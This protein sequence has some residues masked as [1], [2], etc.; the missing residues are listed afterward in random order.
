MQ[1]E[2]E[3]LVFA[4]EQAKHKLVDLEIK[5]GIKQIPVPTQSISYVEIKKEIIKKEEPRILTET[6][7]AGKPKKEKKHKEQKSVTEDPPIDIG[8]L[9]LR[10][11]LIMD[12]QRH[13]DADSLYVL[14][15]NCKEEKPRTVCSGLVKHIPIEE[16][17]NRSVVLLCNLKPVK[18]H[19]LI[20][21]FLIANWIHFSD[22]GNNL[23]SNGDVCK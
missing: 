19:V 18:V 11:G 6:A 7:S 4:V 1:E 23:R 3:K 9:D 10:I 8:R 5:N 20:Q 14:K 12:V 15:I 13:P 16:L 22:E 21:I 2:N 17:K